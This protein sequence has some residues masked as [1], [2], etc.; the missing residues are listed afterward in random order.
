MSL[1]ENLFSPETVE[2]LGWMLVHLLWQATA[3]ALL[4]V[5]LLRLMRRTDAN[6]RYAVACGALALMVVLPLITM[7]VVEVSGPAAEAGPPLAP[8]QPTTV[9]PTPSALRVADDLPAL[10]PMPPLE[11]VDVTTSIPWQERIV[12]VL[13]PAL[14]YIVLGWLV[15]VFGLSAWHLGGWAQLQ[16]LKRRMTRKASPTVQATL[17][18]LADRLGV[19]R[20]VTLLESALVEVPT[21]VGW[22]RPV[23]LLPASAL[24][25]LSPDQLRAILAHELAHIRRYDYLANMLQTVIEILGFYHPA[26]WWVAHRIRVERENCCDDLAVRIC[27]NSLQYARALT[28]MEEM[29]HSRSD[30]AMAAS[31]GSLMAR[32]AR[33]LGRPAVDDRRFA[34]LPG[35]IALLLVI[36]IVIPTAVALSLPTPPSAQSPVDDTPAQ[37]DQTQD[38][39]ALNPSSRAQIAVRFLLADVFCD[40]VLDPQT[41]AEAAGLL[42]RIPAEGETGPTSPPTME[43][44]RRPL[45]DVFA[46][47]APA[48]GRGK[49]LVDLLGRKGYAAGML[50]APNVTVLSGEPLSFTMGT[51]PTVD[52][53]PSP[54]S[55]FVFVEYSVTATEVPDQ[56]AVRLA[57]ELARTY[58]AHKSGGPSGETTTWTLATTALAPNKQWITIT[59]NRLR[60]PDRN[61]RECLQLPLVLAS[62]VDTPQTGVPV[63]TT[64]GS[65]RRAPSA[66]PIT[67]LGPGMGGMPLA[68]STDPAQIL[69]N[70]FVFPR[71]FPDRIVDHE[72][73]LLLAGILTAENPYALREVIHA[74]PK[75]NVTLGEILRTWVAGQPMATTTME[76]LIDVLQSRGY[77]EGEARLEALAE[78]DQQARINLVAEEMILSSADP[79]SPPEK[80]KLGTFVQATPRVS[81]PTSGRIT[82]EIAA[83]WKER[84]EPGD[85]STRPMVCT[86]E[87]VSTLVVPSGQSAALVATSADKSGAHLHL[88]LA[89]PTIVGPE[90]APP[91]PTGSADTTTAV[92]PLLPNDTPLQDQTPISIDWVI[93]K[94]L[95]EARLDRETLILIADALTPERPQIVN[96]IA[97][98]DRSQHVT[99]GDVLRQYVIRQSLSPEASQALIELLRQRG[100]LA[101]QARPTLLVK[102]DQKFEIRSVSEE[103]F[104]IAPPQNHDAGDESTLRKIEYGTVVKGTAHVADHNNVT[105]EMAVSS[106]EPVPQASPTGLPVVR[107]MEV[108]TTVTTPT[109][110]YFSLLVESAGDRN[111]QTQNS[112]SL[113]VMVRPSIVPIDSARQGRSLVEPNEPVVRRPR[114]VLL[115][116]RVVAMEHNDM[117]NLG[118][119]WTFPTV[120]AG[121]VSD[122]DG[123]K[124]I[125]IGYSP[126]S[127]F[128]DSLITT[129]NQFEADG[130]ADIVAHPQLM[131]QDGRQAQLRSVQEEWFLVSNSE[132]AGPELQKIGSGTVLTMT[133]RVG[134]HKEITV[135]M[136]VEISDSLPRGTGSDLPIVT[137][138]M[139]KNT[140]TIRDGGT[141]ALAGLRGSLAGQDERSKEIAILVTAR[142]VPETW[143]P[144]QGR[145]DPSTRPISRRVPAGPPSG[146][147]T[148]Q[149]GITASFTDTDLVKALTQISTLSGAKIAVDL[150]VKP[151]P[152]TVELLNT[153]VPAA[154]QQVLQ[155]TPYIF[156]LVEEGNALTYMVY[157][158]LSGTFEGVD[159]AQALSDLAA[160]ADVPIIPDPN[161]HGQVWTH[162]ENVPL[163][164]ALQM[165]LAGRP[166]FF[167][168]T[169]HYYLVGSRPVL[170]GR[171]SESSI[172]TQEAADARRAYVDADPMVR[173]LLESIVQIE[174]DL[175]V[176]RQTRLGTHPDVARKEALLKAFRDRLQ[177]RRSELE[178]GFD[179]TLSARLNDRETERFARDDPRH[180]LLRAT[181]LRVLTNRR[182]D[183]NTATEVFNMIAPGDTGRPL[184]TRETLRTSTVD[185][186]L[187]S[188][189]GQ[190]PTEQFRAVVQLLE[191]KRLVDSLAEPQLVMLAGRPAEISGGN[192]TLK[193]LPHILKA[194]QTV[195]LDV[196]VSMEMEEP[197]PPTSGGTRDSSPSVMSTRTIRTAAVLEI[198]SGRHGV[199]VL[200]GV[201]PGTNQADAM[202]Y[203]LLFQL[204]LVTPDVRREAPSAEGNLDDNQAAADANS[205]SRAWAIT[206]QFNS[207]PLLQGLGP[208][209][210]RLLEPEHRN[211]PAWQPST[212][213]GQLMVNLD[214]DE[215]THVE[216]TIGLFEDA[217][218]SKDPVAVRRVA[219]K[220][221]HLLTKLP[222]GRFQIGA[223]VGKYAHALGV[224]RQW[225]QPVEIRRGQ[226]TSIR[227]LV[228]KASTAATGLQQ[229]GIIWDYLGHW[230]WQDDSALWRGRITGPGSKPI[231]FASIE[232]RVPLARR[233]SCETAGS[234]PV[235]ELSEDKSLA[236]VVTNPRPHRGN[237][238]A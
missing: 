176:L 228:S 150:T 237:P 85:P 229:Q 74:D 1:L 204:T 230:E 219:G 101:F 226:V 177:Q 66:N 17:G 144:Q 106:T 174:R 160:D 6:V 79:A 38:A 142:L 224:Q 95:T 186:I 40:A 31:G 218:W 139:A 166:Y 80:V 39:T 60:R 149:A 107:T 13:K 62:I 87:L 46:T 132:Q 9:T 14:P 16:R 98:P 127:A 220:G 167:E 179:E 187:E 114:Q 168:R 205:P 157:R 35:L 203:C 212:D 136:T 213:D 7:Q 131:A 4:L 182:L 191:S 164:K 47:F 138:R 10:S 8:L 175:I 76:L 65:A 199:S 3:V 210:A 126:D 97:G 61:G 91:P 170:T 102:D 190:V 134:D 140:V 2:R 194:G 117:L 208:R 153:S 235:E 214:M 195:R 57:L 89:S 41:A 197:L 121:Q 67:N 198:P 78:K 183:R 11:I 206:R 223:I 184:M 145:T 128:T 37:M 25:G 222:V 130:R 77:L 162:F 116:A 225:P 123:L 161:V 19:H 236:H 23:I 152:I 188:L 180:I 115:D 52:V 83:Q 110:Q 84:A 48:V 189:A 122:A 81:S 119:E 196:D 104:S 234:F 120:Q 51:P 105:L 55:E 103:F 200:G 49:G 137:R 100:L 112:E 163:E 63:S 44:L 93:A 159:L 73:R 192:L 143:P 172:S 29:R 209:L 125:R 181:L 232:V 15:G 155:G 69:M 158:P 109:H 70:F 173:G 43:E 33:L 36:S 92:E 231:P 108:A 216:V 133:P 5:V 26:V 201:M 171:A 21:V 185:E 54:D 113:L 135:E 207:P 215:P 129:L 233:G 18:E 90:R 148:R 147:T 28:S 88:L 64:M 94:V 42:V 68:P 227:L 151:Q 211:D 30:L 50:A 221:M 118:V 53:A 217:K 45:A 27:G 34:W 58:A 202:T 20:A 165:V 111:A 154:I 86:S 193:V 178:R 56:N 141:V 75:Q 99:L 82:L 32:V 96:G 124:G 12:M 169:P 156:E 71:V 59:D 24:T 72:T 22:L 146:A 238:R